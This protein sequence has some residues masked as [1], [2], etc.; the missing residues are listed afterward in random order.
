MLFRSK[1]PRASA[2][3]SLFKNVNA[4]KDDTPPLIEDS[5]TTSSLIVDSEE[6]KA[7]KKLKEK[8]TES[9]SPSPFR[10][11]DPKQQEAKLDQLVVSVPCTTK[12]ILS[13]HFYGLE[14]MGKDGHR[15]WKI[16]LKDHI[17]HALESICLIKK[18]SPVP[19]HISEKKKAHVNFKTNGMVLILV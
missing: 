10:G 2:F 1:S 3:Q 8:L 16:A 5:K 17:V 19:M 7:E 14:L 15:A 18:L 9:L 13:S 4:A 12:T 6:L 11:E